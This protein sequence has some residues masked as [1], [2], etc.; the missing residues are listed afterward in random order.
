[1]GMVCPFRVG[2][3]VGRVGVRDMLARQPAFRASLLA[4]L[5]HPPHDNRGFCT[6]NCLD[7]LP[8]IAQ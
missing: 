8:H 6:V 1:M 4:I 5:G 2:R 7:R 3:L